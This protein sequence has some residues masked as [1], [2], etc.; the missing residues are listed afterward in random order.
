[1]KCLYMILKHITG[2]ILIK[3]DIKLSYNTHS[4]NNST[5]GPPNKDSCHRDVKRPYKSIYC[6][7]FLLLD[8]LGVLVRF[9]FFNELLPPY[10]LKEKKTA[11]CF[12]YLYLQLTL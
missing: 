4:N 2:Y 10:I 5:L 9:L 1:M 11:L 8:F 7:Y 6:Y 3:N 12:T